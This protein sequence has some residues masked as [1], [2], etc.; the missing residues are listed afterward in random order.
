MG[1][2]SESDVVLYLSNLQSTIMKLSKL[3]LGKEYLNIDSKTNKF[4]TTIYATYLEKLKN[5]FDVK[6]AKFATILT[7]NSINN[8]KSIILKQYYQIEEYVHNSSKLFR[9]QINYFINELNKTTELFESLS[10]YIYNQVLGY[11]RILYSSIQSKYINLEYQR[12]PIFNVDMDSAPPLFKKIVNETKLTIFEMVH[13]FQTKIKA[14]INLPKILKVCL[15]KTSLGKI[16]KKMDDFSKVEKS[17]QKE[18]PI[19]FPTF[20]NFQLRFTPDVGVGFGFFASFNPNWEE[21]K[22][23]LSFE[24]YVEAYVG[25][26]FEG[27]FYVPCSPESILKTAF[28]I[29]FD[30]V[31]GHGRAGMRLEIYLSE[32]DITFDLYIIGK[33]LSFE[34][35]CQARVEFKTRFFETEYSYDFFRTKLF[36]LEY[37][38][39]T[40]DKV[41]K[42]YDGGK[43]FPIVFGSSGH[44]G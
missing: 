21:S 33:A 15:S 34:F 2:L 27:G 17:F 18:F 16:M 14:E 24:V 23:S 31:I 6:I 22:F 7:N 39:H 1:A 43:N 5:S 30:G 9:N 37:E 19:M 29:G 10:G 20:P 28:A 3:Y 12:L 40:L 42:K 26:K 25:F 11:Y 4:L 38:K 13:T 36:E 32:F 35:Y 8:L 44:S 41:P